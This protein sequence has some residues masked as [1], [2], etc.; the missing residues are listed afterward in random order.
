MA[1]LKYMCSAL[2]VIGSD[3]SRSRVIAVMREAT[4]MAPAS[5]GT[6]KVEA[7]A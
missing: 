5:T 6:D 1:I 4:G 7:L 2:K 3:N